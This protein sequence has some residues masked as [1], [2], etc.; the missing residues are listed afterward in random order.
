M[1]NNTDQTLTYANAAR[2]TVR[3][4]PY[5]IS[6]GAYDYGTLI[7]DNMGFTTGTIAAAG[8]SEGDVQNN[9]SNKNVG[10]TGIFKV[11]A[12]ATS[13]DGD[14]TLYVE[15]SDSDANWPS[16]GADFDITDLIPVCVLPL[17]TDAVDEDRSKN[18]EIN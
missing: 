13:T 18:F 5:L 7:T 6:S 11:V 1:I 17:T 2:V 4:Q 12:D 3:F 14:C 9:S 15:Y 10:G 8:E 16:D